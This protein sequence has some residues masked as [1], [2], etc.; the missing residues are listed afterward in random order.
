M[1]KILVLIVGFA[2]LL[3]LGFLI[4]KRQKAYEAKLREE[5]KQRRLK[6]LRDRQL[7]KRELAAIEYNLECD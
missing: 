3:T 5:A 2:I 6:S 1:L 7:S 4:N